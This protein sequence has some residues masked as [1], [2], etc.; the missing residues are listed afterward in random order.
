M[1]LIRLKPE[2]MITSIHDWQLSLD[3]VSNFIGSFV[4]N[5]STKWVIWDLS[6]A[7]GYAAAVVRPCQLSTLR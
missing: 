2:P 4:K 3:G 6:A 1:N 7:V 5:S